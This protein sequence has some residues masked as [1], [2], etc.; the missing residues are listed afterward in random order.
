MNKTIQSHILFL[1][2]IAGSSLHPMKR[3]HHAISNISTQKPF[4][5]NGDS[6]EKTHSCPSCNKEFI[7]INWFFK[8]LSFCN[9]LNSFNDSTAINTNVQVD[10]P[11]RSQDVILTPTAYVKKNT[12]NTCSICYK[13]FST[14]QGYR[15]HYTQAH[16][17][18]V[19]LQKD[20][21]S[22]D[23]AENI[24][25]QTTTN[26]LSINPPIVPQNDITTNLSIKNVI[27]APG[28]Y[29]KEN[30]NICSICHKTFISQLSYR[31]HYAK[32]HVTIIPFLKLP[33]QSQNEVPANYFDQTLAMP[34]VQTMESFVENNKKEN[35]TSDP[36]LE[37]LFGGIDE[38]YK[39]HND[40]I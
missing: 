28:A 38:W 18:T 4:L 9:K 11:T 36:L 35:Q 21:C 23:I 1:L 15:K 8:H 26:I 24:N 14:L 5:V 2:L 22:N 6:Y 37:D 30:A 16:I 17:S 19:I 31:R 12:T 3:P 39:S 20:L 34:D 40:L 27:L 29:T 7:K 13:T 25:K 32:C 33:E 10:L